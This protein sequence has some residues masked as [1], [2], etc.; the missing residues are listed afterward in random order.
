MLIAYDNRIGLESIACNNMHLKFLKVGDAI[1]L[2]VQSLTYQEELNKPTI[3]A[4]SDSVNRFRFVNVDHQRPVAQ[5][6][7]CLFK[8][9]NYLFI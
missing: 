5:F 6:E 2:I 7:H 8:K 9:V 3:C 4:L 1:G